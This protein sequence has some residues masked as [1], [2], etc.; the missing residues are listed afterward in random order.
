MRKLCDIEKDG[1]E[2]WVKRANVASEEDMR[3]VFGFVQDKFG[4]LD[5]VIFGVA[6][7]PCTGAPSMRPECRSVRCI[8]R[9]RLMVSWSLRDSC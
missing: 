6:A 9:P 4:R 8:S 5:G 7:R 3:A 2:V 1:G